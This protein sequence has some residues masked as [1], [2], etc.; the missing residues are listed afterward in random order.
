MTNEI[1]LIRNNLA[2]LRIGEHDEE[3]VKSSLALIVQKIFQYAGQKPEKRDIAVI[4]KEISS[5]LT[6]RYKGMTMNEV[7]YAL[8]YGVKGEYGEYFGI[9]VASISKW[10]KA[11]YNSEERKE[12]Q[13]SKLFPE[14]ALPERTGPTDSEILAFKIEACN[15]A[16]ELAKA[17][18]QVRDTGNTVYD[19]LDEKGEIQFTAAE[20]N[21]FM[22]IAERELKAEA[23]EHAKDSVRPAGYFIEKILR[24]NIIARAKKI[25]LNE[26]FRRI[27]NE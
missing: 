7:D 24:A 5:D 27:L 21:S 16:F 1:V 3:T 8:T 9:N 14:L 23:R 22:Q 18:K 15:R 17:G 13:R 25:A 11:Y 20:K 6:K 4:C 12:A 2:G 19:F 10:I 26:H